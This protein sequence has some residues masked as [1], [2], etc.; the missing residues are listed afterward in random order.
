MTPRRGWGLL[1]AVALALLLWFAWA[2]LQSRKSSINL[3]RFGEW[4]QTDSAQLMRPLLDFGMR[5]RRAAGPADVALP[6]VPK[7]SGVRAWSLA[8]DTVLR[9]EL[10]AKVDG[11]PVVLKFVPVIRGVNGLIYDCV[12]ATS[13]LHVGSFCSSDV[14]R[15][16]ADIAAQLDANEKVIASLPAVVSA[17]GVYL[18]PGAA[19]GSV[20]VVPQNANDLRNCGFQCVKPQS[21]VTPRPLACGKTVDEGSSGWTELAATTTDFRGDRFATRTQ[22]DKACAEALGAGYYVLPSGSIGGVVK[23]A[24]PREYWLHDQSFPAKN[25][26]KT[27]YF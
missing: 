7:G 8:N 17:S 16:V 20:V 9:V 13:A 24:G 25:C 14:V 12:S 11:L 5:Y 22:A 19:A 26:W 3:E 4:L 21:C 6:A 27:D 18:P 23:L 10:D 15:S 2:Q 1:L